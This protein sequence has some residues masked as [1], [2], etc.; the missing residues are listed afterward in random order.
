MPNYDF[1]SLND[2]EFEELSTDLLSCHLGCRI[3]RFKVGRDGGVDGRFFSTD[4]QEV[5]IQCKHWIKSGLSALIRSIENTEAVKV[6]KLKPKRYIF[7][8]S[9]ALSRA[10]KIAIKKLLAPYLL[11]ESDIFGNEDLNDILSKN[12]NVE[13]KHYKLWISS[14][15]VLQT[16]FSSG[17]VGRSK[18]K[19]EEIVE[20]SNRYVITQ[21]HK[22]AMDKLEK[23][24]SVIITGA[25]GVGK[26]SLADQL[27]LFYTAND[28][29]FCFIE[30]SLNEAEAIYKEESKQVFYFD[31][32]LG[33][34]FLLA[35]DA[36]QDSHVINFIKRVE[37]DEN[38][39]FILTSRSN[40][41]NQGKRLS[42]LF[43]IK[44]VDRN[45]YELS[46]A[47]LTRFDKAKILYNHIWFGNLSEDYINELYEEK[48]YLN[49]I[50]HKNFNPRLISFIT[51]YHRLTTISPNEYWK[52]IE[53]TL[54]NPKDIW[55]NVF[56]VQLDVVCRHIVVAVALH[57]EAISEEN[58]SG[59]YQR[60]VS[61]GLGANVD[62]SFESV[63]R[64]L[65]G[66]LLNRNVLDNSSVSYNLFNPS[67]ADY[68]IA[69]Y[70]D[71]FNYVDEILICLKTP[72]SISNIYSSVLSRMVD[73]QFYYHLLE[74]QLIRLSK[75]QNCNQVDSYKLRILSCASWCISPNGDMLEYI[76][77]LALE[78]L[79]CDPFDYGVDY[80]EFMHWCLFLE[81]I[82]PD[83]S[84]FLDQLNKWVLE[85]EK[86]MEEF[87]V[88]SK[89]VVIVEKVPS[90]LT[91]ALRTQY[92]EFLSEDIT[93]NI[94]D[95]GVLSDAYD[96]EM[97]DYSP[98]IDYITSRLAELEISFEDSDIEQVSDSCDMDDVIQANMNAAMHQDRQYEAYK[99]QGN[100]M[101]PSIDI[102]SDLF[103]RG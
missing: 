36:H 11:S 56:D 14:T 53:Q 2:K 84:I 46:I 30:N 100:S 26:T 69:N 91:I 79:R 92:V 34:N 76:G 24:H 28:Y 32:F 99:D 85:Y 41:L 42:D 73:R 6:Q 51:D 58:L 96:P 103:D 63:V 44:K 33:R 66:A 64:L 98:L 20:E 16:I 94:I 82:S 83:D 21:S 90:T 13:R 74:S 3:E 45:E 72:E 31:D 23:I 60:V 35:L 80:F 95:E 1:S 12:A 68:V 29:E 87:I 55:R 38:K 7:V 27:C 10:N 86:N 4:G 49:I 101:E 93:R 102:I 22:Q 15:N 62:K 89:I 88:L 37:K 65:V 8:T 52:Y 19:L 48:R 25:P 5:I 75:E 70:L 59:L 54:S 9:L 77:N 43:E 39:R 50:D 71:N 18:F 78:V 67:I 40:I 81:V 57:G 61:G 97:C 17:I 47:S